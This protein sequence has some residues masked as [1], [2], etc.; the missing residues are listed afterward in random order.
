MIE[1]LPCVYILA[2]AFNGTLYVGVTSDL[3]GRIVQHR[4]GT[5]DGFTKRHGIHRLVYY[6]VGGTMESAI[7]REKQVKRYRREW[8][9]NLIEREN[10]M[11]NDLAVGLGLEPLTAIARG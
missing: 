5:F 2:S 9:R 8:K 10:P 11:W 1:R 7:R 4:A 3:I 6:E